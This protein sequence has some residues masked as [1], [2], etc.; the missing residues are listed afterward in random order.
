MPA[1]SFGP[2]SSDGIPVRAGAKVQLRVKQTSG[3]PQ[4]LAKLRFGIAQ[5]EPQGSG[6]LT[7]PATGPGGGGE[8]IIE[9]PYDVFASE[10]QTAGLLHRYDPD[11]G[12]RTDFTLTH[13][14]TRGQLALAPN[15][16]IYTVNA[17]G[18]FDYA[19]FDADGVRQASGSVGAS[20]GNIWQPPLRADGSLAVGRTASSGNRQ[21]LLYMDATDIA[22]GGAATWSTDADADG[23]IYYSDSSSRVRKVD[24]SDPNDPVVV[25]MAELLE[26][27]Y[28]VK[29]SHD[30]Q[31]VFARTPNRLYRLDTETGAED[32][33][34]TVVAG[35]DL[36]P[37]TAVG[38]LA[39]TF[40]G[41]VLCVEDNVVRAFDGDAN[42]LWDTGAFP[43]TVRRVEVDGE[44][45]VYAFS[46]TTSDYDGGATM[47]KFDGS[48]GDQ[49]WSDDSH[50]GI[51]L[52]HL[53]VWPGRVGT[54]LWEVEGWPL[55]P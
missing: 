41:N 44:D 3:D 11:T 32:W 33:V 21:W 22:I 18:N 25:W 28:V 46:G 55:S 24:V 4:Q 23:F 7:L 27:A 5:L 15:R 48:T 19:Q 2:Y 31:A 36:N 39:P 10:R 50:E 35:G 49:L 42:P 45:N 29:V 13:S 8:P 47:R 40:G 54:R 14:I 37:P 6:G 16:H 26:I 9:G 20:G 30:Q 1:R 34:G 38:A 52:S 17:G 51:D 43:Q 53:V 12:A